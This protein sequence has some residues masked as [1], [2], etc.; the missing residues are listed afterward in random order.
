MMRPDAFALSERMGPHATRFRVCAATG[1]DRRLARVASLRTAIYARLAVCRLRSAGAAPRPLPNITSDGLSDPT[2]EERFKSAPLAPKGHADATR[3]KSGRSWHVRCP[4]VCRHASERT[5][6]HLPRGRGAL[7][8][9][10]IPQ[11]PRREHSRSAEA[12]E[13]DGCRARMAT[14]GAAHA[15]RQPSRV[16]RRRRRGRRARAHG[17]QGG[18]RQALGHEL[19]ARGGGLARRSRRRRGCARG[20]ASRALRRAR[21]R[22]AL[23]GALARVRFRRRR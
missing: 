10:A 19:T 13:G 4:F 5:R 7:R 9:R 22:R 1:S 16:R 15:A 14:S 21:M 12:V 2:P 8:R 11:R 3:R 17:A 23:R 18:T 6:N 20:G